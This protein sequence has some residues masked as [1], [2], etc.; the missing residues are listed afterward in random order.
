M[1]LLKPLL[2][3]LGLPTG[4]GRKSKDRLLL[5]DSQPMHF[6]PSEREQIEK[7]IAEFIGDSTSVYARYY[8]AIVRVNALPL[9]CRKPQFEQSLRYMLWL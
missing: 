2:S 7:R 3:L 6:S 4:A 1:D 8:A 5:D 9:L